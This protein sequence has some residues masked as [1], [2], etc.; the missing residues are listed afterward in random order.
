MKVKLLQNPK[1]QEGVGKRVH[2]KGVQL[3]MEEGRLGE[4]HGGRCEVNGKR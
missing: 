1:K 3:L 4:V 2:F